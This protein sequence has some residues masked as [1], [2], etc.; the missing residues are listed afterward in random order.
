MNTSCF[1]LAFPRFL[2]SHFLAKQM[3]SEMFSMTE[4]RANE[5]VKQNPEQFVNHNKRQITRVYPKGKRVDSSNFW[6]IVGFI[7]LWN[8]LLNVVLESA[9][10]L[11]G[12][13]L[14]I[15]IKKVFLEGLL[16]LHESVRHFRN[17]GTVAYRW[18]P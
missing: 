8:A 4:T 10:H 17:S 5:L 7:R 18:Q 2:M 15:N 9:T 1:S 13:H 16:F 12:F 3:S 11:T 6:P 14:Q